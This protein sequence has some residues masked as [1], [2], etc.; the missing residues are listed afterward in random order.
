MK[1][2]AIVFVDFEHWLIGYKNLYDIPPN[3]YSWYG[4]LRKMYSELEIYF[5]ADFTNIVYKNEIEMI[6]RISGKIIPTRE[7]NAF[8][9]KE[10]TDFIM[11]DYI[12]QKGVEKDTPPVFIIFSG[13]G[14][15]EPVV[16]F[17]NNKLKKEV[18]VYGVMGAFSNRLKEIAPKVVEVPLTE[19]ERR[20]YTDMILK[21][22]EYISKHTEIIATFNSIVKSVSSYN[23]VS[24]D[25][26][27]IT[28]N[29]LLNKKWLYKREINIGNKSIQTI[30]TDWSKI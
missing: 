15:F 26:I 12:Y 16:R 7:K 30:M 25:K 10:L 23:Y 27:K 13:D 19:E 5:F 28:L 8:L 21:N 1:K 4:N 22:M 11:L 29:W 18:I 17:L 20:R 6:K 2:K 3:I 9:K 14:H 24:K